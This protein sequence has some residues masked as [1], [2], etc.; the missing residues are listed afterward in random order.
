MCMTTPRAWL[1]RRVRA[2]LPL[3]AA[4]A[5]LAL[6]A[7]A[8]AFS[9]DDVATRAQALAAAPYAAPTSNLPD[10]FS[11][12]QFDDYQ[13][14]QPRND[15]FG[16]ADVDT[17]FKLAFYHQGMQFQS[18]VQINEIVDG[19]VREIAYDPTRFDFGGLSF[20]Q[21]ATRNLGY[22]GFRVLYPVNQAGKYDEIM[23]L[24]GASYFRVIG[25][26]Q[27]YGLSSRGLA[28]DS[29]LPVPEEFPRFREYWL[30]RPAPGDKQ[31]TI[32]ALLDS[33]RATGAY[34][35]V[36]TPGSDTVLDVKSRIY[37]RGTVDALGIAPLTS[38]FLFGPSQP[39]APGNFRPAIH[40]SN[41]LAMHAAN[42]EWIW[43]PLNDPPQVTLSS[44][45]MENPRG[46]GLLQRG[47]EFSRYE[48]LK[49][50]Y[51]LRPSAWI[52][53]Q[54]DWGRGR[55]QLV[56]LPTPDETNDNIVAFWVPE[57]RPAAGQPLR[58]DY[59]MHWTMDEPAL[60]AADAGRI[61]WVR[62]T[63]RTYGERYQPNLI[64]QQDGSIALLVDFEGPAL[65]RLPAGTQ[66]TP[67]YSG[68]ANADIVG[69]SLLPNPAI[70]GWRLV[71][72]F[73]ARD[74]SQATEL[75][76]ALLVNGQPVTETWSYQ[77]P[78]QPPAAQSPAATPAVPPMALPAPPPPSDQTKPPAPL[79]PAPAQPATL[80]NGQQP[81]QPAAPAPATPPPA[82]PAPVQTPAPSPS[83]PAPAPVQPGYSPRGDG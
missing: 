1:R 77:L 45:Q 36:L 3:L 52:E 2:V 73:K 57:Q 11:S 51:D 14:I 33:P 30:Q 59:R 21:A 13:K 23:S 15:R 4:L 40:D 32:Y 46:F 82:E 26:G 79:A 55:V 22:A 64:R 78:A 70:Q 42:G 53:P 71:L 76:A 27:I 50:R 34:Q 7:P 69:A 61:G 35:F 28:I 54:G 62:Q 58:F 56:E 81:T 67:Q 25:K 37:L 65:A 38:M 80:G 29:G 63:L 41:G 74:P 16:W 10:V 49:D 68:N 43:R 72:R 83:S 31:L 48:D 44:Y 39:A 24:L 5:G 12:M 66:V 20:D 6:Q 9:L 60:F 19:A 8:S 17:P 75:R 18:P 47:R